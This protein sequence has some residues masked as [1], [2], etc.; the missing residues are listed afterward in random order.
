MDPKLLIFFLAVVCL[1]SKVL[2]QGK[3]PAVVEYMYS[4]GE[5]YPVCSMTGF[6]HK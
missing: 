6:Y 3:R 1:I 4:F 2:S 5:Y